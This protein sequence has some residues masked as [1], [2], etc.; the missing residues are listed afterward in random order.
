M[1]VFLVV[2]GAG[3]R[4]H[5]GGLIWCCCY[6]GDGEEGWLGV[7]AV[8]WGCFLAEEVGAGGG[9]YFEGVREVGRL[10]GWRGEFGEGVF[11]VFEDDG[12]AG[13]RRGLGC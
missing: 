5:A 7:E 13:G 2:G 11:F 10:T 1:R 4:G 12:G 9:G 6:C 3:G 8:H